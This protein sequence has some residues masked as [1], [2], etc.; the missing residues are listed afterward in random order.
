MCF[1][2]FD[3]GIRCP[4]EGLEHEVESTRVA[5]TGTKTVREILL[6]E[7]VGASVVMAGSHLKTSWVLERPS[8]RWRSYP[9]VL[10]SVNAIFPLLGTYKSPLPL[11]GALNVGIVRL[12]AIPYEN[13]G[14]H[15][16]LVT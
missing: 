1:T 3:A 5:N 16:S 12:E 2:K 15:P 4:H 13:Y 10:Q 8:I 14:E 6:L 11:R 7:E 9:S